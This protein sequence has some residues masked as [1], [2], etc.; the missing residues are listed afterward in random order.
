MADEYSKF[1]GE[2]SESPGIGHSFGVAARGLAEA[3]PVYG[4]R[5]AEK[6]NLPKAQNLG[7]R[8]EERAFRNLPYNVP[9][10]VAN[11]VL[12]TATWLGSVGGGQAAEEMGGG[13][14]T[15]ATGEIL[16]GGAPGFVRGVS[17]QMFGHIVPEIEEVSQKAAKS[18]YELGPGARTRQGMAYGSGETSEAMER[19]LTKAT[20]EA[21]QRTGSVAE[22]I[23]ETWLNNTQRKLG[24]EVENLFKNRR[25]TT[26]PQEVSQIEDVLKKV[27][28][29]F[30]DQANS[31]RTIIDSNIKGYRPT[32]KIVETVDGVPKASEFDAK[33]LREAISQINAKL[34]TGQNP[35]QNA[36]LH[37]LKDVLDNVAYNNLKDAS[38]ALAKQYSD[39]KSKYTAYATLRD[40]YSR[41]GKSGIDEAGKINVQTLRDIIAT[42]SGNAANALK[43]P[44]TPEL[45]EYGDILRT[46]KSPTRDTLYQ[47][48]KQNIKE[49]A[50]PK[51]IM[52]F[53][54]P[55]VSAKETGLLKAL[56]VYGP[57]GSLATQKTPDSKKDPYSSYT[58]GQ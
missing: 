20:K 10:M 43:N 24:I 15:Q 45:A 57:A 13:P 9:L 12:G 41:F 6:M 18:G 48:V 3:V 30:G 46:S 44:L 17:G 16:G 53:M 40:L 2:S 49:S 8:T 31:V 51:A 21:T 26:T 52:G 55:V 14:L 23:D 36:L 39:W 11:P 27:D 19:N 38:P 1:T 4:E 47:S 34:G 42:R 54:Q 35:S 28:Q 5:F 33:G 25:F 29:A 50:I 7:E 32:G 37:D 22:K 58:G 56:G